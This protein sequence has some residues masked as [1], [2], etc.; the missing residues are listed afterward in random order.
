MSNDTWTENSITWNNAPLASGAAL[1]TV[2]VSGQL[3]YY[4]LDV[5][6]FVQTQL[7]GDKVVSFL[8]KD[9]A[10]KSLNLGF[11]SKEHTAN[12]PQLIIQTVAPVLA[13]IRLTA[14]VMPF[15]FFRFIQCRRLLQQQHQHYH[16]N[17]CY[18]QHQ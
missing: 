16:L 17:G 8:L 1:S 4:E 7:A 9:A 18:C 15:Y 3:Q 6:G 14:G 13:T 2:S 5:T 10:N 12:P 11:N